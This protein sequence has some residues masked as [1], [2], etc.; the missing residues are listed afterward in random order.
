MRPVPALL[1]MAGGTVVL[2]DVDDVGDEDGE[3]VPFVAG[4]IR[5]IGGRPPP[6]GA[7]ADKNR[8]A[9]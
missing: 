8:S 6:G 9:V 7:P 2:V 3:D 1:L 4:G 5:G